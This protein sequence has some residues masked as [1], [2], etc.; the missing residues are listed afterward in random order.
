MERSTEKFTSLITTEHADKPLFV[1]MIRTLCQPTVDWLKQADQFP[2]L[3][4]IDTAIGAQLDLLGEWIGASRSLSVPISDVYFTLDSDDLGFDSGVWLGPFD[5]VSGLVDLPDAH[6][7][8]LLKAKIL[9]N[10][11]DC[12]IPDAYELASVI[13]GP[14]GYTFVLADHNDLTMDLGLIGNTPPDALTWALLTG[15]Y[16]NLKPVGVRIQYYFTTTVAGPVFALDLD[17]EL[18]SGFDEGGWALLT[19]V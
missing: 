4:E 13:F 18:F 12:D 2:T 8:L 14:L 5:P 9:N 6:Y 7:R 19:T 17:S 3:T 15:G 11:W 1:E 16:F 10:R